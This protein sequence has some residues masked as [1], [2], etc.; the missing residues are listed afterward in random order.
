MSQDISHAPHDDI[1]RL[2]DRL[3]VPHRLVEHEPIHTV[4]EGFR[5]GVVTLLGV[6]AGNIVK[7]LLITDTHG[8]LFL[9]CATA[10][11][12]LDLK[13]MART[14]DTTRMSFAKRQVVIDRLGIQ[15]GGVSLFSLLNPTAHGIQLVVDAGLPTLAGDIGFPAGDNRHTVLFP[16][17]D[18]ECVAAEISPTFRTITVHD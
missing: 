17:R 16:A 11:A 14:L 12:R 15:P 3:G 9:V 8:N 5:F 2:L 13:A 18:L 6:P 1:A 4:D 10:D 7:N